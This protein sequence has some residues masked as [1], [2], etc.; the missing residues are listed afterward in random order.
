V[1]PRA[2][3]TAEY[4]SGN[5]LWLPVCTAS[6]GAWDYRIS[7]TPNSIGGLASRTVTF[8]AG[9]PS[10]L[11]TAHIGA[12]NEAH[13]SLQALRARD[14]HCLTLAASQLAFD[15]L[16]P[17]LFRSQGLFALTSQLTIASP[18]KQLPPQYDQ[19]VSHLIFAFGSSASY[20]ILTRL[21]AIGA[22]CFA[23]TSKRYKHNSR[24]V[25][26]G[27]FWSHTLPCR[28]PVAYRL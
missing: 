2:S 3:T 6:E 21:L 28:S 26:A 4:R 17:T 10:G 8:T 19:L 25:P 5:P 7:L 15:R 18:R 13:P 9:L 12:F 27:C 1:L 14:L 23:S 24:L 16:T 11:R 22:N 20:C